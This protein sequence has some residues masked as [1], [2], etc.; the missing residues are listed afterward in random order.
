MPV[1][2]WYWYRSYDSGSSGWERGMV[3][4]WLALVVLFVVVLA[5]VFSAYGRDIRAARERVASGS[6]LVDTPCGVIEYG[7]IGEGPPVLVV[8][9]AGGGFDQGLALGEDLARMGFQV[10]SVSRFGYLRTPLPADASAEA[11]ADAHAC[12]L[13]A[14]GIERAFVIGAS[15]GG[16]SSLQLALR[17]PDRVAALVLLVPAIYVPRPDD[18]EAVLV[19]AGLEWV[20]ETALRSDFLL[21]A[22]TRVL[23]PT[24]LRTM[25]ATPPELVAGADADEQARIR[26]MFDDIL[27]VSA[28]RAGLVNDS[29]VI[30]TLPRYPLESIAAPTLAISFED[31]LFG[32]Y[33]AA[34]YAAEHIPGARFVGYPS[35]GHVWVGHH[36]QVL[37]DIARFFQDVPQP[38]GRNGIIEEIRP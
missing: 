2:T 27:P 14:L 4:W 37:D 38:A 10:V 6:A 11:Q 26:R 30:G 16:P 32:T 12:V 8:H 5:V 28:R 33:D 24:L 35:G 23:R 36:R 3:R 17:H 25:F 9:G 7:R 34:R 29:A 18:A 1:N 13:D 22:A 21:W 15:A 31:D 20:F 19:P